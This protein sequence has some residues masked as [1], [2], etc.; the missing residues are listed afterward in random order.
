MSFPTTAASSPGPGL[1]EVESRRHVGTDAAR[2][3]SCRH[4]DRRDLLLHDDVPQ[5]DGLDYEVERLEPLIE[6]ARIDA[7]EGEGFACWTH[8]ITSPA[9]YRQSFDARTVGQVLV[10][11]SY[12]TKYRPPL[13]TEP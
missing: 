3:W 10:S 7:R 5:A 9:D 11:R 1:G 6:A 4:R 2:S 12:R 13:Q 8:L